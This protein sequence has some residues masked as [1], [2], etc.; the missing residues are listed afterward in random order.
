MQTSGRASASLHRAHPSDIEALYGDLDSFWK[1]ELRVTMSA[2]NSSGKSVGLEAM[3][4]LVHSGDA[5]NLENFDVISGTTKRLRI[6]GSLE[7]QPRPA[8]S[9]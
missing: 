3:L 7:A 2:L 5:V 6:S 9:L 4:P 1:R 8:S